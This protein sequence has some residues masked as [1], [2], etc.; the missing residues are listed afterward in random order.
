MQFTKMTIVTWAGPW[1]EKPENK[2]IVDERDALFAKMVEEGKT[3]GL[4]Y[5]V[6]ATADPTDRSRARKW[7]DQAAAEEFKTMITNLSAKYELPLISVVISDIP[8]ELQ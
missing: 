3:D 8:P 1:A 7:V 5:T 6:N 2:F 4:A